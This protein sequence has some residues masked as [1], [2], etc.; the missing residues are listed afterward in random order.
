MGIL[1]ENLYRVYDVA[2][3]LSMAYLLRF[4]LTFTGQRW[5]GTIAHTGTIV[6]LPIITYIITS[7]ISGNIALS[8][9]MVGALSI[10]RFRNPVR[11]PLE[12]SV[13]FAC[14]TMGIAASVN[15]LW[16]LFLMFAIVSAIGSLILMD[17]IS[18]RIFS[19]PLFIKSFS[20]GNSYSMLEVVSGNRIEL[21][22]NSPH[23]VVVEFHDE[24][25]SYVLTNSNKATLK[26][27][28]SEVCSLTGIISCKITL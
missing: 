27:I 2:V 14:V 15:T 22:E 19:A 1:D 6:V 9:G 11:S 10:V 7:V 16:L 28:Y 3:L 17:F 4:S 26:Q 24:K 23:A 20:E 13:Y 21:L 8:L 25:F 5:A 18:Q 12:L